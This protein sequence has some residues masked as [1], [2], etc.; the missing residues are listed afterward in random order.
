MVYDLA[1]LDT[2]RDIDD[3]AAWG[4]ISDRRAAKQ[5]A[6]VRRL[7]LLQLLRWQEQVKMQHAVTES[8]AKRSRTTDHAGTA[9]PPGGLRRPEQALGE[10]QPRRRP[11]CRA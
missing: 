1:I 11:C 5:S 6:E 7:G 3:E 8:E 10:R 9:S 2:E 4:I